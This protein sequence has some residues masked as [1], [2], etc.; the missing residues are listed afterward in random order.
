MLA[1]PI[2]VNDR[3]TALAPGLPVGPDTEALLESAREESAAERR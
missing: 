1:S 2:K 3:R